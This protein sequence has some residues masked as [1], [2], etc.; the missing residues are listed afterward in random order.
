M[1]VSVAVRSTVNV[2]AAELGSLDY[3]VCA[4]APEVTAIAHAF[5]TRHSGDAYRVL[6]SETVHLQR[7]GSTLHVSAG[8]G[9]KATI[10]IANSSDEVCSI[11]ASG[12]D[13]LSAASA[14][15]GA[16][17]AA[18]DAVLTYR[19]GHPWPLAAAPVD[20][21]STSVHLPLRRLC[22]SAPAR[23]GLAENRAVAELDSP[24]PSLLVCDSASL[25]IPRA[26]A[27]SSR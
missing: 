4:S 7:S 14:I 16:N 15:P 25:W 24:C 22:G 17:I 2:N 23:S 26:R 1:L 12:A 18:L 5:L 10:S 13:L 20:E 19:A 11:R 6:A 3:A 9:R 27:R 21:Q 8:A